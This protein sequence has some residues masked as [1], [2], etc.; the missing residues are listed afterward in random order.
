VSSVTAYTV[1]PP[2]RVCSHESLQDGFFF[3]SANRQL[4][5]V[6]VVDIFPFSG[7]PCAVDH[8]RTTS[9]GEVACSFPIRGRTSGSKP[10]LS[11]L[12]LHPDCDV[13]EA[14]QQKISSDFDFLGKVIRKRGRLLV[15]DPSEG[16]RR[17]AAICLTQ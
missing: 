13:A 7:A 12:Y 14:F 4:Q 10:I 2:S 6:G 8:L 3:P 15:V 17:V 11:S 1:S 5:H 16:D 9:N